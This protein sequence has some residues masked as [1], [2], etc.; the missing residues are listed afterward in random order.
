MFMRRFLRAAA[1]LGAIVLPAVSSRAA[2][3]PVATGL[4]VWLHADGLAQADGSL[5]SSWRDD[6][7]SGKTATQAVAARQP[8]FKSL[9]INGKPAVSFNGSFL[10]TPAVALGAFTQF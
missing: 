10:S 3:P 8:T 7:G 6:S 9:G 2:V 4:S 5:V 1:L